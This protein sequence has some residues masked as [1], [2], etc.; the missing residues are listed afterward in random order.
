MNPADVYCHL[1]LWSGYYPVGGAE[2]PHMETNDP[3]YH[4][5]T[6]SSKQNKL[7]R[8]NSFL[9]CHLDDLIFSVYFN[10]FVEPFA[11]TIR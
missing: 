3:D 8:P 9:S 11:Y 5:K 1:F 4:L 7:I 10:S 2:V 6:I